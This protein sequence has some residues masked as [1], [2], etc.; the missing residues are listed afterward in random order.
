[1]ATITEIDQNVQNSRGFEPIGLTRIKNL[2]QQF[3]VC[4]E[5]H[6]EQ[7][8]VMVLDLKQKEPR[9]NRELRKIGFSLELYGTPEPWAENI[10]P[11]CSHCRRVESA[12]KEIADWI[13]PR[14]QRQC[15]HEVEIDAQSLSYSRVRADRPDVRVTIQILH[16]NNWEQPIDECEECCL[17]DMERALHE[18]GACNGAWRPV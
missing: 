7:A 17:K 2:V 6:P 4:W 8:L 11:G 1:M 16:Q 3:A 9:V 5:S 15:M 12:L 14:E 18:L 10:S 13:L